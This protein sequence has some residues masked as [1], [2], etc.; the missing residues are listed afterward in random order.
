MERARELLENTELQIG[1]VANRVGF[2]SPSHFSQ[3]FRRITG[4]APSALR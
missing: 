4:V 2:A 1:E 3:Q